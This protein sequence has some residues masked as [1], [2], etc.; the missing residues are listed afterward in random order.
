MVFSASNFAMEQM[1]SYGKKD[2]IFA[3]LPPEPN[4]RN[5]SMDAPDRIP[6]IQQTPSTKTM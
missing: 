2:Q 6:L 1:F 4:G 5:K 3:A